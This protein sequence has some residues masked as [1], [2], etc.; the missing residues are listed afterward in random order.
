MLERAPA[1]DLAELKSG[2]SLIVVSTEGVT[3]SE[4]MAIDILAGVEPILSARPKNSNQAVLGSWS[5]G[6]NGG[7]GGP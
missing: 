7:E 3:P 1:L 6:M 5:L 2:D 4:V